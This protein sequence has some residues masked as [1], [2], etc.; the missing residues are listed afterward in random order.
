LVIGAA[1]HQDKVNPA[2]HPDILAALRGYILHPLQFLLGSILNDIA[3]SEAPYTGQDSFT[4]APKSP[5]A[6]D[7]DLFNQ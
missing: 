4:S 6:S 3:L 7:Y 5:R 1:V 2:T